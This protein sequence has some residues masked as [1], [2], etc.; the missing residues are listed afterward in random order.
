[1]NVKCDITQGKYMACYLIYRGDVPLNCYGAAVSQVKIKEKIQFVDWMYSGIKS[2]RD[3]R[4]PC[5]IKDGEFAK[6]V[7]SACMLGNI[8][9]LRMFLGMSKNFDDMYSKKA[10]VHWFLKEG[11][12]EEKFRE[13]REN[14]ASLEM[15]YKEIETDSPEEENEI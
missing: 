9:L 12:E 13:V 10:F 7:R 3:L 11:W 15:N 14:F 5:V 6:V 8:L 1:M 4:T 2:G